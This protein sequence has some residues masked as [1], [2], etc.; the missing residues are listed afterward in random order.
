MHIT[1]RRDT[2]WIRNRIGHRFHASLRPDTTP[3]TGGISLTDIDLDHASGPP[4]EDLPSPGI[5]TDAA[6]PGGSGN[7][8]AGEQ[9]PSEVLR[10]AKEHAYE[11]LR[12]SE[13][14]LRLALESAE[15]GAW[16][17]DLRSGDA[18]VRSPRHDRIFGYDEPLDDWSLEIFLDHV[19]PDDR[20]SVRW[21]YRDA[22]R[23]GTWGFECRIIRADGELRWIAARG[24]FFHDAERRPIRAIGTVK[25][26]T[27][28]KRTERTLRELN[29]TLE[30]RVA[31]RTAA[32]VRSEERLRR[33]ASKLTMAE[34]EERRRISQILHNDLQQQL[35]GVQMKLKIA[36]RKAQT[37]ASAEALRE[38]DEAREW[39]ERGVKTTRQLTVDLSPPVLESE[40]LAEM[41]GWLV[42]QMREMH[43]LE[44]RLVAERDVRLPDEDMRVLLFQIVRELLFNVVKHAGTERATVELR[45]TD[46]GR[47]LRIVDEGRGFDVER[48]AERA[49]R[50]GGFGLF[51][52]HERLR[53]FGGRMEIDSAP[54][55]GT[56]VDVHVPGAA[57]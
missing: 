55:E 18:P 12:Q 28:R 10:Q 14:R 40:G 57:G 11:Q 24:E 27:D 41:L 15:M 44:V 7:E 16:E 51:S 25:D 38:L 2:A 8:A 21:K 22:L 47:V 52:I 31:K 45:R 29:E 6:P 20:E 46:E 56:R 49:E 1:H 32:L 26:I 9:D 36:R 17:L 39:I 50:G 23:E 54:G 34:Q 33:A 48:A 19:H 42:S 3:H 13:E 43:G 35:H 30:E 5:R 4:A 53:L 37:G